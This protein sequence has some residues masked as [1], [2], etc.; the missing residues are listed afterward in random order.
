MSS[1]SES[2]HKEVESSENEEEVD[3]ASDQEEVDEEERV[4]FPEYDFEHFEL[5]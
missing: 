4:S 1:D 5:N 2:D 3:E